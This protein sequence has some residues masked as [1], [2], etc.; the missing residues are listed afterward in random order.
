MT[1]S[2]SFRRVPRGN[3]A[4]N[5]C[6]SCIDKATQRGKRAKNPAPVEEFTGN[7]YKRGYRG[8][9]FDIYD[10]IEMWAVT[11]P[12]LQHA[13]KKILVPG[14]RGK[15]DTLADLKEA[16]DALTRAIE[17]QEMREARGHEI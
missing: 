11:C 12:A 7:K 15:N 8:Q 9:V 13:V 4:V 14:K 2:G 16:R 6:L 17:L 5:V 10:I 3:V 1:L